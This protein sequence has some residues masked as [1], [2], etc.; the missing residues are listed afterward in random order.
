MIKEVII[1]IGKNSDIKYEIDPDGKLRVDR[2]LYG[3]NHYPQNYGFIENTLDWDGDPLDVLVIANHSFLPTTA[4]ETKILGAMRMI[5]G[6]ETDTKLIGVIASDVR[7]NHI[8]KLED[9]PESLLNEIEDF[10]KNYKNLQ[11]KKV[12]VNG[13]LGI[14]AA[15]Q[16]LE[17]TQQL[18]QKYKDMEKDEF[19]S[20]MK[21]KHPEKY[22]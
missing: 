18:Y 17:E 15:K 11:N 14:E 3:S 2:I 20:L 7:F 13:F 5:D 10:F 6:G 1:E 16:E 9:V 19:I 8:N 4:V 21:T 22:S 12:E